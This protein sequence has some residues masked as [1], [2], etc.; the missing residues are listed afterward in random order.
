MSPGSRRRAILKD[1]P[2]TDN[3]DS[4]C[5]WWPEIHVNM[6]GGAH[7]RTI[8]P[9][10]LNEGPKPIVV[11]FDDGVVFVKFVFIYHVRLVASSLLLCG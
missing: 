6:P 8:N 3:S 5:E 1:F 10:L 2:D 4:L 11:R 9:I 7:P